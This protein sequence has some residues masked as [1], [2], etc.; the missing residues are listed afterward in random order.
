VP[1]VP[2]GYVALLRLPGAAVLLSLV[3]AARLA[4]GALPL[5][6]LLLVAG[7]RSSYA[8]A[9]VVAGLYALTA[10]LLGPARARAVDRFGAA[11]TLPALAG[12]LAAFLG[13]LVALADAPLPIVAALGLL[14]GCVPPTVGPVMRRAWRALV[15]GE[16]DALRRAYALDAVTEE[17]AFVVGPV[18][19]AA[20]IAVG[21]PRAVLLG[22]LAVLA[23]AAAGLGVRAAGLLT[24]PADAAAAPAPATAALWR[25]RAFVVALLPPCTLGLLLGALEIAAVALALAHAGTWAT[26]LPGGVLAA[27]SLA[28]GLVYGGRRWP[29]TAGTQARALAGTAAVAVLG[30]SLAARSFPLFVVAAAGVGLVVAPAFVATYLAVDAA[31]PT[32]GSEATAWVNAVFNAA[33]AAGTAAAGVVVDRAS[34]AAA[35]LTAALA[36]GVLLAC[37][38]ISGRTRTGAPSPGPTGLRGSATGRA[39]AQSP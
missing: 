20:S 31:A 29:G 11:R 28:G 22:C 15:H 14:A 7:E 33:A 16:P 24:A 35:L 32:A 26:G 6:L 34:P 25:H 4:Y 10:G 5:A 30:A 2:G 39:P 18:A 17:A 38:A 9:G 23:V 3:S 12:A 19:G 8:D 1:A 27:G 21:G 13:L 36:A 37:G